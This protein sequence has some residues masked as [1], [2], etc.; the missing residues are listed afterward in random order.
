[1][2]FVLH[3]V[4]R[5]PLPATCFLKTDSRYVQACRIVRFRTFYFPAR[6]VNQ[7]SIIVEELCIH[8]FSYQRPPWTVDRVLMAAKAKLHHNNKVSFRDTCVTLKLGAFYMRSPGIVIQS[9]QHRLYCINGPPT[10]QQKAQKS[11][12]CVTLQQPTHQP[13]S[14]NIGSLVL[15]LSTFSLKP[16]TRRQWGDFK[17]SR[18][19]N[20]D[21]ARYIHII[22]VPKLLVCISS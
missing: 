8:S 7:T 12:S 3:I 11:S 19:H 13:T 2:T 1:M 5:W 4:Y 20:S 16:W 22:Y 14:R 17:S 10:E 21:S 18:Q 15:G 9:R 6:L